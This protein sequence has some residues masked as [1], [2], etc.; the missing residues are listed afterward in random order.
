MRDNKSARKHAKHILA[1]AVI[2]KRPIVCQLWI[3]KDPHS[4]CA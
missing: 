4:N 2:R 3:T 1:E